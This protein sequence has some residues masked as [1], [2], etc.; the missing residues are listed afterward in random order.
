MIK[1]DSSSFSLGLRRPEPSDGR[2]GLTVLANLAL[3]LEEKLTA[4]AR[5]EKVLSSG[6]LL[7]VRGGGEGLNFKGKT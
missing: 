3:H 7:M 6:K 4:L 2:E 5:N 1:I